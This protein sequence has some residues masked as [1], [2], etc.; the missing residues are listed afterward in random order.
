MTTL[1]TMALMP[2]AAGRLVSQ[3]TLAKNKLDSSEKTIATVTQAV[4]SKERASAR[5]W[6]E[7]A[8]IRYEFAVSPG[9]AYSG[10]DKLAAGDWLN[11]QNR[12]TI[13][14]YYNVSNPTVNGVSSKWE[15]DAIPRPMDL[16]LMVAF[17]LAVIP[18]MAL[19]WLAA[20]IPIYFKLPFDPYR[21]K[22]G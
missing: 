3:T 9:K 5:S 6:T 12:K 22:I 17:F 4:L 1:T 2:L 20:Y 16:V 19:N 11:R 10:S 8:T 7:I 14:I 13:E 21:S 15:D 18:A